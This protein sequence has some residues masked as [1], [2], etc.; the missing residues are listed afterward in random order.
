MKTFN[1]DLLNGK[2]VKFIMNDAAVLFFPATQQH[3]DVKAHGLSYEDD[4][5]GNAVAGL[6]MPDHVEIRFHRNFS[7]ERIG[8][9]WRRVLASPGLSGRQFGNLLYQGR[10]IP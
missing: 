8:N 7:D 4:Y 2:T 6:V 9:I 5:A 1:E 3:R 10:K